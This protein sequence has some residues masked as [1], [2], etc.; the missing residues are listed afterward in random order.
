MVVLINHVAGASNLVDGIC[1][2]D[3][4]FGTVANDVADEEGGRRC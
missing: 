4:A 1:T 2:A 3:A